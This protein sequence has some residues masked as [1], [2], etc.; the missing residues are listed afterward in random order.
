M[1]SCSSL[2][3]T[4]MIVDSFA[5]VA[6]PI[7]RGSYA[8][9]SCIASTRVALDVLHRFGLRA[10]ALVARAAVFNEATLTES[11]ALAA[12]GADRLV[13]IVERALLVDASAKQAHRLQPGIELPGV[14]VMPVRTRFI[15][16]LSP[17]ATSVGTC[18][19]WY[20]PDPRDRSY[21]L[22]PDWQQTPDSRIATDEIVDAMR[23]VIQESEAA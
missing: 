16:G 10:T 4:E 12:E 5:A 1:T 18:H 14:L 13:V 21:T 7:I 17:A 15:A 6:R 23:R 22:T 3:T 8:A 9:N 2:P 11:D 20:T 19:V